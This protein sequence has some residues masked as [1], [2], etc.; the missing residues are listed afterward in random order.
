MG[1]GDPDGPGSPVTTVVVPGSPG[2][3]FWPF[4]TLK[5]RDCPE[6]NKDKNNQFRFAFLRLSA[7]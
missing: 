2:S 6:S 1:P 5:P 4:W 3:P 7:D